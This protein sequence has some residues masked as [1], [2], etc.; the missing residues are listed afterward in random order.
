MWYAVNL[1]F[2]STHKVDK[3]ADPLWEERILLMK[4]DTE[5]DAKTE[6]IEYGKKGEHEYSVGNGSADEST[7]SIKW[8]FEQIERIFTID[9]ESLT[10]G[11]E[12]FSR[13]LRDSEVKSLLIPFDD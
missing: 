8:S 12:L 10:S 2:K 13:Y 4:A 9:D 11:T 6:A 7:D 3:K 1:L 5:E